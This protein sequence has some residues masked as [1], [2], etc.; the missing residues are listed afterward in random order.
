MKIYKNMKKL[1]FILAALMIATYGCSSD[2][3][4]D[5]A[6]KT[7][8]AISATK[9]AASKAMDY[10][11]SKGFEKVIVVGEKEA[12][13]GKFRVKDMV[14][15]EEKEVGEEDEGVGVPH[16]GDHVDIDGHPDYEEYEEATY[17]GPGTCPLG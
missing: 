2:E 13:S 1:V 15:G 3:A 17:E 16:R 9:L 8:E 12:E 10:A 7:K 6:E 5:A 11:N 4:K 14:S